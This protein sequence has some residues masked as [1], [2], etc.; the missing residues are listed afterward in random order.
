[1]IQG[2][3]YATQ[4]GTAVYL[5]FGSGNIQPWAHDDNEITTDPSKLPDNERKDQVEDKDPAN[6]Q[7]PT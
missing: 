2:P 5:L 4:F 6:T 7:N 1:M 3:G